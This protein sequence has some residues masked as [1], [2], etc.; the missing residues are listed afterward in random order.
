MTQTTEKLKAGIRY[1]LMNGFCEK[2]VYH[3]LLLD[4]DRSKCSHVLIGFASYP[5]CAQVSECFS[6][7]E[8]GET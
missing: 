7:C 1:P 4:G 6:Y 8:K 3:Y 2:C 5:M